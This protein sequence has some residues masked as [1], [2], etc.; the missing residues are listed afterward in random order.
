MGKVLTSLLLV[1]TVTALS[2]C[3]QIQLPD[4]LQFGKAAPK[5]GKQPAVGQA[6]G[7]V[8]IRTSGR[9]ITLEDFN[10]RVKAYNEEIQAAQDIPES[11]KGNYL[12]KTIAD[13]RKLLE[14]MLERELLI[15]EAQDRGLDQDETVVK[16]LRALEEE[17]L[18]VRLIEQEKEKVTV[19]TRDV[20]SY[21]NLRKDAF[22]MPEERKISMIAVPTESK[23]KALLIQLLQGVN[24]AALA[25][26]NSTD[27]S[28]ANGGNIGFIIQKL[29]LPQSEK[30]TMFK[31]FE[32]IAF[33]LEL[34]KPSTIFE[35]PDGFYLIKVTEIKESRQLLL[36]EVFKDIEQGLLLQ[37]QDKAL[38]NLIDHLRKGS[39]VS[40]H[41][42]LLRD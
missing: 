33:Y 14:G 36:S 13:K 3:D 4:W 35:G 7:M 27:K 10:E 1:F 32:D 11:V 17:L 12:I 37:K 2:G 15:A 19:T 39:D 42:E 24:F 22:K 34:N 23:A 26:N 41:Q 9:V 16:A 25:R 20:E 5:I 38:R 18:F 29:P 6:E 30:K 8:L 28:A 21:Y 31:K 40:I